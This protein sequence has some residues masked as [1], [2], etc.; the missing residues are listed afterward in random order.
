MVYSLLGKG[1][2]EEQMGVILS[3]RR[4]GVAICRGA[5]VGYDGAR[6]GALNVLLLQYILVISISHNIR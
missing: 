1:M 3:W 5:R 6:W 2:G 4:V